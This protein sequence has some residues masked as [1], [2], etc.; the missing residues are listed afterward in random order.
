V[1]AQPATADC[2]LGFRRDFNTGAYSS[3]DPPWRHAC[4]YMRRDLTRFRLSRTHSG[5]AYPSGSRRRI[6]RLR[7]AANGDRQE[8]VYDELA[9]RLGWIGWNSAS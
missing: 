5:G 7:G 4:P 1:L 3:W 8:Q 6:P 9:D 2:R